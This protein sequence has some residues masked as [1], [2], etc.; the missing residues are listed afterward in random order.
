MVKVFQLSVEVGRCWLPE[1]TK[2]TP[3]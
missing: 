2:A 3:L 1:N